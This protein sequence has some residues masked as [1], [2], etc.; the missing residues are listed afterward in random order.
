MKK[1][2]VLFMLTFIWLT[3]FLNTAESEEWLTVVGGTGSESSFS[4][5]RTTDNGYVVAGYT[6]SFGSGYY[7]ILIIKLNQNGDVLWQK[8][9]GG[10]DND[11]ALLIKE[12]T[13]NGFVLVGRTESFGSGN[14]DVLVLKVDEDGI[15]QW[16]KVY[17]GTDCDWGQSIYQ[18]SD[19]GYVFCG[20][21]VSFGSGNYDFWVVKLAA[22]G[23]VEWE[24][25]YGGQGHDIAHSISQTVDNGYIVAGYTSSFG[26]GK[27]DILVLK[28]DAYG[29]VSWQKTYGTAFYDRAN[30]IQQTSDGGYILAGG[31]Q[32]GSI[33][34]SALLLRLDVDGQLVWQKYYDGSNISVSDLEQIPGGAF[35][36][37]GSV[38]SDTLI[39]KI[40][41]KGD[42]L[43]QK[44]YGGDSNDIGTSV[45]RSVENG[46]IVS[47]YTYS[48]GSGSSD[49]WVQNIDGDGNI[50][51]CSN[52]DGGNADISASVS[53]LSL[54]ISG[55]VRVN[56]TAEVKNSLLVTLS[57]TIGMFHP[58]LDED[59]D[60]IG[61]DVD[62][63][64]GTYNPEQIDAD[65]DGTGDA[66][67][68]HYDTREQSFIS[69]SVSPQIILLGEEISIS[70]S[71][72]QQDA[73]PVPGVEVKVTLV[74]PSGMIAEE[75]VTL[76]DGMFE[77][78][79]T[80]D[81][82]GGWIIVA[83]WAGNLEYKGTHSAS[84]ELT[85]GKASVDVNLSL[86]ELD[87]SSQ[88]IVLGEE[89]TFL[90]TIRTHNFIPVFG[91][92]VQL[93]I[94]SP[95]GRIEMEAENTTLDGVF[96]IP[97]VPDEAGTWTVIASWGGDAENNGSHS[98]SRDLTVEKA[99]VELTLSLSSKTVLTDRSIVVEGYL[100]PRPLNGFP[101]TGMT[102]FLNITGPD[103]NILFP[104]MTESTG[105]FKSPDLHVFSL[106]GTW[107]LRAVFAGDDNYLSNIT[108]AEELEVLLPEE[109]GYAIIVQGKISNEEGIVSHKKSV[110]TIYDILAEREIRSVN[111]KAFGYD[112]SEDIEYEVSTKENIEQAISRWAASRINE[113][114]AP[115]YIILIGH[116]SDGKFYIDP[117]YISPSDLDEWISQLESDLAPYDFT[118][119]PVY[120]LIGS[121][122]SGSFIPDT[123]RTGRVIITS[124]AETEN[125][126]RGPIEDNNEREGSYF[127]S[128]F[129]KLAARGNSIE[130]SFDLAVTQIETWTEDKSI[131]NVFKYAYNDN[132]QQHP[133]IDDNG[134][135]EGQN[136]TSPVESEDGSTQ[137]SEFLGTSAPAEQLEFMSV[138]PQIIL[139]PAEDPPEL[140]AV[141]NDGLMLD[142]FWIEIKA[143][144]YNPLYTTEQYEKKND[145]TRVVYDLENIEGNKFFFD[146]Y[147]D[148]DFKR[149]GAHEIYYFAKDLDSQRILP[150]FKSVVYR[151]LTFNFTPSN[152][153][154]L[155]PVDQSVQ[156]GTVVMFD[157]E[158]ST[159]FFDP[160]I[161]YSLFV[162]DNETFD[163]LVVK[164]DQIRESAFVLGLG[165]EFEDG[166]NY[167]WKV[168]AVDSY[169]EIRESTQVWSFYK[170]GGNIVL[171]T[172]KG[173]V[174]D[175]STGLPLSGV[176]VTSNCGASHTSGMDGVFYL[177]GPEGS[178]EGQAKKTG[179]KNKSFNFK[180]VAGKFTYVSFSMSAG[181]SIECPAER[182]IKDA[183]TL[184]L[185][186]SYRDTVLLKTEEG[187]LDVAR[188]Y[189]HT[190][191]VT[192]IVVSSPRM[193]RQF[194]S[195]VFDM[196][197]EL[198]HALKEK[199][200]VRLLKYQKKRVRSFL[201]KI[202]R[203]SSPE[204]KKVIRKI[205]ARLN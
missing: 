189:I 20:H 87:I 138:S 203:K 137:L 65:Q 92:L 27:N 103:K 192:K 72:I 58:C 47:G 162:S 42:L 153:N 163:T 102:V 187:R 76:F 117:E 38:L 112:L 91:A 1:I 118:R 33:Y 64:I 77:L 107:T 67:S 158:T 135:G 98:N 178:F 53:T 133:L 152:F 10:A 22:D 23:A 50:N 172:L 140:Y 202:Y 205:K 66:C 169:G 56:T 39:F 186:R 171:G 79:F 109:T 49:I 70:G 144:D 4:V 83:S 173:S 136:Y 89:I 194:A 2:S 114:S 71:V 45:C 21:T 75:P 94:I 80:P 199:R 191:E 183:N 201:R 200:E 90:G 190:S 193:R 37:Y 19:G 24:K 196:L 119:Y 93:I 184:D 81:E 62:N 96:D 30:L 86:T 129:F 174:I 46:Y 18:T 55:L 161:T 124:S 101:K 204:L 36:L 14:S 97:F 68:A 16:Q 78:D 13:D 40:D 123:S 34:S 156:D 82:V 126:Y 167:Y 170:D 188:Y 146:A 105:R 74:S 195:L 61:D 111:I 142:N 84:A 26:E 104:L 145:F 127:L 54:N 95:S 85:V 147:G 128:E 52:V 108:D 7:D 116:G 48:Y 8:T 154:L 100:L 3:V 160:N 125:A 159:D 29:A 11:Y 180:L 57:E 120:L 59:S 5:G 88:S 168:E 155:A 175:S 106:P 60:G 197:I 151:K 44:K 9:Y 139:E 131:R 164:E 181:S 69:L 165:A 143:P 130:E 134:D 25:A 166:R 12:T 150:F 176:S 148:Y 28:L 73:L 43:W 185:L 32:T 51:E 6:N 113:V 17:G 35:V 115:L 110:E 182:T 15:I 41:D 177:V 31:S 121:C 63:C 157:W 149:P 122:G 99:E 132:A 179:Y 198:K 141:F